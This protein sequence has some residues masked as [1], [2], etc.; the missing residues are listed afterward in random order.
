M[1]E[2]FISLNIQADFEKIVVAINYYQIQPF[3]EQ[4]PIE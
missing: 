1:I 4:I 2:A 3:D